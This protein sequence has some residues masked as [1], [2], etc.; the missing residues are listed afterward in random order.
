MSL[1]YSYYTCHSS[2]LSEFRNEF[3]KLTRN[4]R[5]DYEK[6]LVANINNKP[7]AFWQYVNSRIKTHPTIDELH[8]PDNTTTSCDTEMAELFN[9]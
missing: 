1:L 5:K 9:N 7:K 6:H 4:L 3:R 8:C 2:E